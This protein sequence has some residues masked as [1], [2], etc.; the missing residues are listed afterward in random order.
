VLE[1]PVFEPPVLFE[2]P[3]F[4]P[5]LPVLPPVELEPPVAD[6]PPVPVGFPVALPQ[7]QVKSALAKRIR[8][9]F[10]LPTS[11]PDGWLVRLD[12]MKTA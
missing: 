10:L 7:P 6:E 8:K 4:E 1:P 11:T 9:A 12:V 2:P 3:V 5:P